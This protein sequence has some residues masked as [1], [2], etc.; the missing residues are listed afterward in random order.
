LTRQRLT[1]FVA[2]QR[3]SDL[4]RLSALIEAGQVVPVVDATYLL[5][6]V[7]EAMRHLEE[8]RVRGKVAILV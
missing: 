3:S 7:S 2:K 4:E 5:E 1:N 6:Q 8:G